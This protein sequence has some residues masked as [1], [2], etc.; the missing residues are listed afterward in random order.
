MRVRKNMENVYEER[1]ACVR[2]CVCV[3]VSMY[4][5]VNKKAWLYSSEIVRVFA[6]NIEWINS[7]IA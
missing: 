6:L 3:R 7:K 5:C 4:A 2:A 1:L